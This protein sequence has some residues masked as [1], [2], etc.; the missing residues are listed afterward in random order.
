LKIVVVVKDIIPSIQG[1]IENALEKEYE[2]ADAF[3]NERG[4]LVV[5]KVK[6]VEGTG[7]DI[8][9]TYQTVGTM[10]VFKEWLYWERKE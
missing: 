7:N 10:A 3:N 6:V 9:P 8:Y 4:E 1:T 5:N 2:D